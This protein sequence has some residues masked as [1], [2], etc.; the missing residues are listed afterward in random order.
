MVGNIRKNNVALTLPCRRRK[1]GVL[2]FEIVGIWCLLA[3]VTGF[4]LG[5]TIR[6]SERIHQEE[7]LSCLFS[8]VEAWQ[9]SR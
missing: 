5:A 2:M 9:S 7:F 6:E 4:G 1:L 8:A 3:V